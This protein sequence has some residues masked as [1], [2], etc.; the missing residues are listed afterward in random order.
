MGRGLLSASLCVVSWAF[1]GTPYPPVSE[2]THSMASTRLFVAIDNPSVEAASAVAL[3]LQSLSG[4]GLG[5]KLGLEFFGACGPSGIKQVHD[6]AP[7]VPIFLDLKF[8]DIPNT[9]AGVVRS[10]APLGPQMFTIHSSGGRAMMEAA[11]KAATDAAAESGGTKPLLIA[12]TVLT[13]LDNDDLASVGQTPPAEDQV[14]RLAKL[15]Q[16]CGMDGVVCS[17][18]EIAAI[19]A[20]CGSSFVLV[21]PGIRPAGAA[22]GDQKRVTTPGEAITAG[23]S[24]L[25]VGRP[26]TQAEDQVAAA[27]AILEEISAAAK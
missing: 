26:I 17:P 14:V 21:V 11:V 4:R 9:V 7:N 8:H 23:A 15:A 3:K 25:V 6:A 2:S 22:V 27:T 10:V 19:R 16:S 13:S 12:V 24:C 18:K 5:I 20:A 1:P